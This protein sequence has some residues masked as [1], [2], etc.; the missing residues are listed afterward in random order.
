[1]SE[2]LLNE[3]IFDA[4]DHLGTAAAQLL[5]LEKNPGS[6]ESL[7]ALMGTMH[8]LKGNSG[9]L[10]LQNLYRFMHHAE[11]LLQTIRE[12]KTDC[13]EAVID[14]L[15]QVMDTVEAILNS[16][17]NGGQDTVGW[18]DSLNQALSEAESRLEKGETPDPVK[19]ADA[20]VSGGPVAEADEPT[21]SEPGLGLEI[22][23]GAASLL[24]LSDGDLELAGDHLPARVEAL[25]KARGSALLVDL[26][27]LTSLTGR[28]LKL[29]LAASLKKPG[30]TAF[31]VDPDGQPDLLRLFQILDPD[32]RL[33]LFP[34]Q[35][36]ALAHFGLSA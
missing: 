26:K 10:D 9:F 11:S 29:L 2:N 25:F 32:R 12:N 6:L 1:M 13:P 17:S 34:D 14:L 16:L 30:R 28:E 36:P 15:L 35:A 4:R 23:P 27:N 3:F 24:T 7:N 8:T 33:N 19:E 20:Y 5:E 21:D 18:L 31:L 22:V